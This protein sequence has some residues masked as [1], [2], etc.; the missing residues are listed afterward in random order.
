VVFEAIDGGGYLIW[1]QLDGAGQRVFAYAMLFEFGAV[2]D[3]PTGD[4]RCVLLDFGLV[5]VCHDY[6]SKARL[7]G[8]GLA[9]SRA[10]TVSRESFGKKRKRAVAIS[11]KEMHLVDS[12]AGIIGLVA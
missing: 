6:S 8:T 9:K 1:R 12:Q 7:C 10:D 5:T 4:A 2:V 11:V 3:Q